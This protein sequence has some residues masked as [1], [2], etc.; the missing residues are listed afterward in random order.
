V[1]KTE[2]RGNRQLIVYELTNLSK[3][4]L[5]WLKIMNTE[6]FGDLNRLE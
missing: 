3:E 4:R 5:E 2:S 1:V 6:L